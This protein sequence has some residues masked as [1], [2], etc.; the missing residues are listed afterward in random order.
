MKN[1]NF[2]LNR[3]TLL[4]SFY[5]YRTSMMSPIIH[6]RKAY[7]ENLQQKGLEEEIRPEYMEGKGTGC[8][9]KIGAGQQ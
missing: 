2:G 6:T 1:S 8:P 5:Y 4:T 9:F 7:M 3:P